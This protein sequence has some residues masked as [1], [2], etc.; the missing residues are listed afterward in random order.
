M[1][2]LIS[3]EK[4]VDVTSLYRGFLNW[5]V[6]MFHRGILVFLFVFWSSER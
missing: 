6:Y 3:M 4:W 2:G 5:Y 1:I